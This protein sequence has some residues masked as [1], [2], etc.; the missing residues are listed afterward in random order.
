MGSPVTCQSTVV[1][2]SDDEASA[3]ETSMGRRSPQL[4]LLTGQYLKT[5]SKHDTWKPNA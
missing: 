4:L 5:R 1:N 3:G 2:R